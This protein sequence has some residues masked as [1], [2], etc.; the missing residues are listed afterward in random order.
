[1]GITFETDQK[2]VV[3]VKTGPKHFKPKKPIRYTGSFFQII[4]RLEKLRHQTELSF[5]FALA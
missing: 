1:M 3:A 5:Y 4:R 2:M